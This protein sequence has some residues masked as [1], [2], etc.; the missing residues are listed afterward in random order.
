MDN[1]I[2]NFL[3]GFKIKTGELADTSSYGPM[4]WNTLGYIF[5]RIK[6]WNSK[7]R[8]VMLDLGSG[9]FRVSFL[10]CRSDYEVE[11][12]EKDAYVSAT[13]KVILDLAIK[14]GIIAENS[15]KFFPETDCFSIPWDRYGVVIFNY[16]EPTNPKLGLEWRKMLAAKCLEL[17]PKSLVAL[18]M[19]DAYMQVDNP[20][21][22]EMNKTMKLVESNRIP[23][24]GGGREFRLYERSSPWPIP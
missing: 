10:G 22:I 8:L 21:T 11:A 18:L 6:I 4:P 16:T 12:V 20:I 5:E 23:D 17:K 9:D 19:V 13:A 1:T 2:I 14:K 3:D 15:I 24:A 7:V